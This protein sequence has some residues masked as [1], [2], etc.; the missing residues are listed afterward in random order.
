MATHRC[1]ERSRLEDDRAGVDVWQ[2]Q[3]DRDVP[4]GY[5]IYQQSR[6]PDNRLTVVAGQG[7]LHLR[8]R[9]RDVLHALIGSGDTMM[10]EWQAVARFMY[11]DV[12]TPDGFW[13]SHQL[14]EVDGLT[15]EQLFWIP[16]AGGLPVLWH[17]GHIA[18]RERLHIGAFLQGLPGHTLIPDRF[19]VFGTEWA[20]V[21]EIRASIGSVAEVFTWARQVRQMSQ[22]YVD[23]LSDE[24]FQVAVADPDDGL[25]VAHWLF[26]TACHTALHIGRIQLLRAMIEGTPERAC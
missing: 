13:Y 15:E 6:I 1:A 8:G 14:Y 9:W 2:G 12:R 26:I 20:P 7:Q 4:G 23:S 18:H 5:H 24:T 16:H 17:V 25:T 22:A 11:G 3:P 21:E 19:E 10:S